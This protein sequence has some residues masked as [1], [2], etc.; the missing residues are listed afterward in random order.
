MNIATACAPCEERG[1]VLVVDD[2]TSIREVVTTILTLEGYRVASAENGA[3][4]LETLRAGMQPRLILLDLRMPG[5]DGW[6]L[7][8]QLN[9]A[10]ELADIPVVVMSGD[11]EAKHGDSPL[12]ADGVL[13][14]P[15]ELMDLLNVVEQHC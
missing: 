1:C 6:E 12:H 3:E 10:P 2:D 4:A 8:E 15:I 14:K 7:C 13:T 5:M 11:R 9:H